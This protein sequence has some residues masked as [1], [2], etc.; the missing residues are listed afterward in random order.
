HKGRRER[1]RAGVQRLGSRFNPAAY[2]GREHLIPSADRELITRLARAEAARPPPQD[3]AALQAWSERVAALRAELR[4]A[5]LQVLRACRLA[6]MTTTRA[7][8]TLK[9]LRELGA[10]GAPPF[11]LVVFDEA[12]QVGLAQALVLMPLGRARLFAG[13]PSQL[14]PVQRSPDRGARRW[15]G[16]SAFA[17]MPRAAPS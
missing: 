9:A 13:D 17:E 6:A 1:W 14:S 11:D 15:L 7:V 3:L 8:G 12:S 5:S 4:A 2:A 16:R 10:G